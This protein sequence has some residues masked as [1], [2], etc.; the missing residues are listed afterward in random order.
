[1]RGV[2]ERLKD[3]R[4]G[5]LRHGV[6]GIGARVAYGNAVLRAVFDVDIVIA[7]GEK[8]DIFE[9]FCEAQRVS[10]EDCFVA[11]DNVSVRDVLSDLLIG[12]QSVLDNVA[13]L[14]ERIGI[15]KLVNNG[16]RVSKYNFHI[17]TTPIVSYYR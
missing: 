15:Y 4:E 1:M 13:Q 2:V 10:V 7:C 12:K 6:R 11:D 17:I 3:E 8:P 14:A 5:V 16:L 9:I